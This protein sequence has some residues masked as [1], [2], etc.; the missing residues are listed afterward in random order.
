MTIHP[1][2]IIIQARMGSTR[3]PGKVL[4]KIMGKPLLA[5]QIERLQEVKSADGIIIATTD[6]EIDDPLEE[7][8]CTID[9]PT[10]RGSEHDVLDRY[11]SAAEQFEAQ[12]VI[13]ITGDCPLIDPAVVEQAI[14][15]FQKGHYDYVSN[16]AERSYPRGMDVEVFSAQIL[17]E[18]ATTATDSWEREHVTPYLYHNPEK[19]RLGHFHYSKD[20]SSHRW[21]VDTEEDFLLV[22]RILTSLYPEDP[23]FSLEDMLYLLQQH[24]EWRLFNGHVEQKQRQ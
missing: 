16:V 20:E 23:L 17:A 21:T 18:A 8:C 11:N 12:T 22:K 10:F 2:Y 6:Q 24:P 15:L 1:I 4:K 3:L 19:Y 13:R 14:Q 5:Y 9:L 7:Y